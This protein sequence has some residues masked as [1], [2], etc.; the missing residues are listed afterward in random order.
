MV[1]L[2][3][4]AVERPFGV[5][6]DRCQLR[7]VIPPSSSSSHRRSALVMP[8]AWAPLVAIRRSAGVAIAAIA[9]GT[10]RDLAALPACNTGSMLASGTLNAAVFTSRPAVSVLADPLDGNIGGLPEIRFFDWADVRL[11]VD[12]GSSTPGFF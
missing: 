10:Y 7:H 11:N 12:N 5:P 2:V 1:E 3:E 4:L 6:S 8:I 9:T